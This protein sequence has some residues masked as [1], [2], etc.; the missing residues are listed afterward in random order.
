ML[1]SVSSL[2]VVF[3]V[4][5]C[6][7]LGSVGRYSSESCVTHQVI[8]AFRCRNIFIGVTHQIFMEAAWFSEKKYM[9]LGDRET[10]VDLSILMFS[11]CIIL[12]KFLIATEASFPHPSTKFP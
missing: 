12:C 2:V 7:P 5:T 11:I 4:V 8:F 1:F 9:G 10:W 6:G 3:A